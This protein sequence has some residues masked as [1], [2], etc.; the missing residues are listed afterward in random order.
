MIMK[1]LEKRSIDYLFQSGCGLIIFD[2]LKL[3]SLHCPKAAGE[4]NSCL[5]T[6]IKIIKKKLKLKFIYPYKN[7]DRK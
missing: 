6:N 2:G 5:K 3:Y 4:V 1:N 7:D